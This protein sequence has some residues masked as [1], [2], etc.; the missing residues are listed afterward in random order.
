MTSGNRKGSDN[1]ATWY[2]N[3][4]GNRNAM[5]GWTEIPTATLEKYIAEAQVR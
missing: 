3:S 2:Q 5:A 1:T 4:C